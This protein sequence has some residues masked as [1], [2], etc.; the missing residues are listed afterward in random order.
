MRTGLRHGPIAGRPRDRRRFGPGAT[1]GSASP[2]VSVS[3]AQTQQLLK[4]WQGGDAAARDG[5][6]ARVLPELERIAA[7]RL[8]AERSSSL[9]TGDLINEA[10]LRLASGR[11]MDVTDR[12]HFFALASRIMRNVLVDQA[13]AKLTDK[14]RHERVELQTDIDGEQRI[15]LVELEVA[16]VRLKA[17]DGDL[18][19]MVEMRYFGGMS[20][21][22]VAIVTSLSEATVKRR[23]QVARAWLADALAHRIDL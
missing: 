2:G 4:D 19:A 12:A 3:L 22:E 11:L 20:V 1:C 17:I 7:A 5:L 8:R 10:L 16:L 14:R 18:V 21:G 13:R 9:S 23:W 6:I 15:D